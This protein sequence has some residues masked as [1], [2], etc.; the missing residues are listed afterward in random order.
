[1]SDD[2]MEIIIDPHA[3]FCFGVVNAI[4]SAQQI[5]QQYHHLY[6][7]GDLVHNN[8]EMQRLAEQGLVVVDREQL[9]QL[10]HTRVLIRAHGE[11]PDTYALARRQ[12]IELVDATCPMV[13]ALQKRINAGYEQM[14]RCGGQIVIFGKPGHAEVVGLN[15][16]TGGSAIIVSAPGEINNIDFDR[17]IR[18]YSQTTRSKEDYEQL[19]HN[20]EQ[21]HPVDFIAY[22]T[23]CSRVS[24]RTA[25]LSSFC[26][27]LDGL[28]FVSGSHSSNGHYLYGF[29]RKVMTKTLFISAA[30]EVDNHV[31]FFDDVR[32]VGI[33][34]ATSTPRWLMDAVADRIRRRVK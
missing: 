27:S 2:T 6:C 9:E 18:L 33:T 12:H 14:C 7:L 3:G 31:A 22:N 11:P 4:E 10:H 34:G 20:I 25:E 29:C 28:V 30:E 32:R 19:I 21:R 5:L 26:R 24:R 15:G 8:A 13:L 16:Q 1:M 17:P 23:L